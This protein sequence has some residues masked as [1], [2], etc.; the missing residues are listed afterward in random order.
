MLFYSP[1]TITVSDEAISHNRDALVANLQMAIATLGVG[2]T[3]VLEFFFGSN[4]VE[5]YE[6]IRGAIFV[7]GEVTLFT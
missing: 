3:L 2:C 1:V 4:R 5:K 6:G 7:L